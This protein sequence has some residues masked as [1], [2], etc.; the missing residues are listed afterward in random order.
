V[1]DLDPDQEE[2]DLSHDHVL[3][4]VSASGRDASSQLPFFPPGEPL[5]S[6]ACLPSSRP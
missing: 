4:M 6:F 1:F 2:V 5:R 3:E